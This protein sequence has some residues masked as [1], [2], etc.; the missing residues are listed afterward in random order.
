MPALDSNQF[1]VKAEVKRLHSI[2]ANTDAVFEYLSDIKML[3]VNI[4][5]VTKLQYYKDSGQARLFCSLRVL[6]VPLQVVVDVEPEVNHQARTIKL[7]APAAPLGSIPSGYVAATFSASLTIT[8]KEKTA[9]RVVSH[10]ILGYNIQQIDLLK[11]FPR[12]FLETTGQEM[13]Q[14]F[15]EQTSANYVKKLTSD[16]PNRKK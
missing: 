2:D 3:L 4:P 11:L 12:T 5:N 13:L 1:L 10:I 6:A 15:V 16:F 9:T 8:P 14:T 7:A